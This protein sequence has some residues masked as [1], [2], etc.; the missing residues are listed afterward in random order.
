MEYVGKIVFDE[1][2]FENRKYVIYGFGEHG[3]KIYEY[4]KKID[5]ENDVIGFCD[6]NADSIEKK[7]YLILPPEEAIKIPD[8]DFLVGGKYEYEMVQFLL[9]H[10]ISR[11]H[12]LSV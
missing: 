6:R 5:K 8:V 3:K 11:I 7:E 1:K 12:I 10:N 4:M 9:K 2:L